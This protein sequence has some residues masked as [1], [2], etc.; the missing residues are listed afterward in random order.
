M[1]LLVLLRPLGE[2][3]PDANIRGI[4]LND[5]P[6]RGLRKST[7]AEVNRLLR[8]ENALSASGVQE[9]GRRVDVKAVIGAATRLKPR[10][11]LL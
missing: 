3:G 5:E 8:A 1:D 4:H 11:K 9:K 6:A 2:D 10:I 7:G